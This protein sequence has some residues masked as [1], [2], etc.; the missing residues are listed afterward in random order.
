MDGVSGF[1]GGGLFELIWN[2][3]LSPL[4][5]EIPIDRGCTSVSVVL[6]SGRLLS[7]I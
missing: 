2:Q 6:H 4:R 5:Q 7:P 1:G 3:A